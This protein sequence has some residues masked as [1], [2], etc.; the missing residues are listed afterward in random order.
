MAQITKVEIFIDGVLNQTL[1]AAPFDRV[2]TSGLSSGN[3]QLTGKV[4]IE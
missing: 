2:D 4:Y 3:H 1:T